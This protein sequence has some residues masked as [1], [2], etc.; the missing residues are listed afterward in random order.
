[1]KSGVVYWFVV[2][3][4]A[5]I[6][7]NIEGNSAAGGTI[8]LPKTGQTVCYDGSGSAISCANTGQDGNLQKGV[9]WPKPRFT[10][11]ADTTITDNLTKLVWAPNG[12]LLATRDPHWENRSTTFDG[13]VTWQHALDYVAKLNTEHYLE[14]DDWRMPNFKELESLVNLNQVNIAKW[15]DGQGFVNVQAAD[16]YWTSTTSMADPSNAWAFDMDYGNVHYF[17]KANS[18]YVWPVRG[19]R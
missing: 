10:T 8:Q 3:L 18:H 7:V 4:S 14:H 2:L 15:L 12:N 13:A 19:G 9:E 1:M 5:I 17:D 6:A 11:N 16:Y